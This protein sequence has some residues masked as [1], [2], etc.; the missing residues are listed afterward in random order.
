MVA[1]YFSF[2]YSVS[3][4]LIIWFIVFLLLSAFRFNAF[5]CVLDIQASILSVYNLFLL[6]F[7][8]LLSVKILEVYQYLTGMSNYFFMRVNRKRIPHPLQSLLFHLLCLQRRKTQ[9]DL[10]LLCLF[11]FLLLLK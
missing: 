2:K 3:I 1:Y 5:I 7:Y 6:I 10:L 8:F 4:S 9:S 11:L